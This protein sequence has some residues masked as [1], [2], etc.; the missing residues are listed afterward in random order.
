MLMTSGPV[1]TA[2]TA[3]PDNAFTGHAWTTSFP[4][5][6]VVVSE[7]DQTNRAGVWTTGLRDGLDW[8]G[9]SSNG[10]MAY[11]RQQLDNAA[12]FSDGTAILKGDWSPDQTVEVTVRIPGALPPDTYFAEIEM[13][14]RSL[15]TPH[16]N[17]GYEI[18]FSV[19]VTAASA[20]CSMVRWKGPF[21]SWN[22]MN[23]SGTFGGPTVQL[24]D[25]DVLR[26]SI[27]GN[28]MQAWK[29]NTSLMIADITD[30]SA[31]VNGGPIWTSGNPGLGFNLSPAGANHNQD[32]GVSHFVAREGL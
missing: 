19:N 14:L 29:N 13:R 8:S 10:L 15:I 11:G 27:F 1:R 5:P 12:D 24:A 25:G 4:L 31:P 32:Y 28:T 18:L 7:A 30:L 17:S 6:E 2:A 9:V 16:W 20:Y 22:Y 26:A 21:G 3:V 23:A